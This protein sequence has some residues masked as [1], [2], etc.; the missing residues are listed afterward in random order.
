MRFLLPTNVVGPAVFRKDEE[1][2]VLSY[3]LDKR[4]GRCWYS[5]NDILST[6]WSH[7][8]VCVA[9]IYWRE[10]TPFNVADRMKFSLPF[11]GSMYFSNPQDDR[12]KDCVLKCNT[13]YYGVCFDN[14]QSKKSRGIFA[15]ADHSGCRQPLVDPTSF[16]SFLRGD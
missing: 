12:V 7:P 14:Q 15:S 3:I 13:L 5:C 10:I 1:L 16:A 6:P 9:F 4:E 2:S 8:I 11:L